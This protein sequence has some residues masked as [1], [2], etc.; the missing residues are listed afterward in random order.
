LAP[1][2]TIAGRKPPEDDRRATEALH[3]QLSKQELIDQHAKLKSKLQRRRQQLA[4]AKSEMQKLEKEIQ[5]LEGR[6]E[7]DKQFG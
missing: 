3:R 7:P 5:V 1:E 6:R 2:K 4:D